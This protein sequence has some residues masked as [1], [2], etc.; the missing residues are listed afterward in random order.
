MIAEITTEL[1]LMMILVSFIAGTSSFIGGIVL[2][3]AI[4]KF[5]SSIEKN[6][7]A[8][9]NYIAYFVAAAATVYGAFFFYRIGYILNTNKDFTYHD[10]FLHDITTG[11]VIL[12]SC[13]LI[14]S[15]MRM[16]ASIKK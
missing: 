15:L 8:S 4:S 11:V 10:W 14:T 13:I 9:T 2:F 5:S 12:L 16:V 1:M 3:I 6:F 7:T